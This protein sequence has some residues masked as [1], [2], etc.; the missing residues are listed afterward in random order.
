MPTDLNTPEAVEH[1]RKAAQAFTK[2]AT[3]SREAALAVLVKEGIATKS[4]KLTKRYR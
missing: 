4:G 1:F 2:S 3:V